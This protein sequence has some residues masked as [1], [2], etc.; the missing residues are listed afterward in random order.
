[1]SKIAKIPVTIKEGITVN[2]ENG[3]IKVD[4]PKGSLFFKLP[5]DVVIKTQDSQIEFSA[6]K[7]ASKEGKALL[8]LTRAT[9]ANMVKGVSEGFEKRLELS[10]VGYRAQMQGEDLVLSLGFSHPVK[11]SPVEGIKFAV[12]ENEIVVSGIDKTIVG[13][14]AAKIREVRIP[15]PYKAKGIKYKGEIIRKKAG[16]A[17]AKT[18]VGGK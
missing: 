4:G 17:A 12:Q 7:E 15:D 13:N 2:I 18:T 3:G 14:I 5:Q 1:M 16:K 9:V 6:G 10:G 8:G 11:F